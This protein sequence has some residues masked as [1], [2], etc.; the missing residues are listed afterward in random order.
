MSDIAR[1]LDRMKA[2]A[3]TSLVTFKILANDGTEKKH[4]QF[5]SPIFSGHSK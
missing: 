4:K 5:Y 2:P 3:L 1:Q